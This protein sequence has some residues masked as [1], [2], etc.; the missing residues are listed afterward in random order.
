[1]GRGFES[2]LRYHQNPVRSQDVERSRRPL[3]A[4]VLVARCRTDRREWNQRVTTRHGSPAR[5]RRDNEMLIRDA[6]PPVTL[7]APLRAIRP[8]L[9]DADV[10]S[11]WF[12]LLQARGALAPPM[13]PR[14]TASRLEAVAEALRALTG[15]ERSL[16]ALAANRAG[17]PEIV[18]QLAVTTRRWADTATR[19]GPR[20]KLVERAMV[21]PVAELWC[22]LTHEAAPPQGP[23]DLSDR[24][25]LYHALARAAFQVVGL[26]YTERLFKELPANC[27][28]GP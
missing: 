27:P 6:H 11:I 19:R 3:G 17:L 13:V 23:A 9:S 28:S 25:R 10:A 22:E 21:D 8:D 4:G 14:E 2:L 7:E 18:D 20:G 24:T 12:R 5:Q 26:T 15:S 16:L 1:M